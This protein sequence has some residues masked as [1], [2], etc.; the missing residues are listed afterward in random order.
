VKLLNTKISIA[1]S[2]ISACISLLR[3]QIRKPCFPL[4]LV[5]VFVELVYAA[6]AVLLITR[7]TYPSECPNSTDTISVEGEDSPELQSNDHGYY[8]SVG[9]MAICNVLRLTEYIPL[10]TG[11]YRY[12]KDE[13]LVS[14][15]LEQPKYYAWLLILLPALPIAL[16]IPPVGIAAENYHEKKYCSDP[17]AHIYYAYCAVNIFRYV[18]SFT[19]RAGMVVATLRVREIWKDVANEQAAPPAKGLNITRTTI[20]SGQN[21]VSLHATLTM[22]YQE[23]GKKV[24]K[25]V[26]IFQ[27]W[28]LLPW[29]VFFLA[30]SVEAKDTL[31]I[32]NEN[33]ENVETL[34]MVYILLYNINQIIF[35]LIPYMCGQKMNHYH[36][37]C[38]ARI[39]D[40]QLNT[41]NMSDN[42]LAQ[43]RRLLIQ[44]ECGYD[45]VPCF[46][47]LGFKVK[48][49]SIIYIIFLVLGLVFTVFGTII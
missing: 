49:S 11:L 35:L 29:I 31:S 25:I 38:H 17:R 34:P 5:A 41:D 10:F 37:Q 6:K 19:V 46:W 43:H 22:E 15:K 45:F 30:S 33:R 18:W 20:S 27:S 12:L 14:L 47:G 28:F 7:F 2:H 48:M 13:N 40:I 23:A 32:W 4:F 16:S 1:H 24:K 44:Q 36:R 21:A 26:R 39:Q 8:F 3:R 9:V 42:D